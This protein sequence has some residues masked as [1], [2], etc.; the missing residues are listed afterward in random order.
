VQPSPLD[1]AI[2]DLNAM[3]GLESVKEQVDALT[4]YLKVMNQRRE[5]GLKTPDVSRHLVLTGP[6]GTG[7]TTVARIIGKVY[8]GLGLLSDGHVVE[9]ARQDLV[10]GYIGQ[11]AIKTNEV[12]DR[13]MGGVLFIDEAYTLSVNNGSGNAQDFGQEA[14]DTLLKRMEDDRGAFAVVVAGYPDEMSRFIDSNPGLASRFTRTIEFPSYTPDE[15]MQIFISITESDGYR[16]THG[17]RSAAQVLLKSAWKH[18]DRSFGNARLVRN[19]LEETVLRQ[20]IRLGKLAD[21]TAETLA[22]LTAQDI[23]A[24]GDHV[25]VL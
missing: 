11:T 6:P 4:S 8:A 15:L 19:L 21:V 18:R 7:K 1:A 24:E 22:E 13:A 10:A 17:A 23:P 2:G 20:S 14:I 12:I 16:L 3:I 25:N 9:V 5:H